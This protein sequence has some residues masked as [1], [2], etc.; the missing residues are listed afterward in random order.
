MNLSAVAK[1]AQA[2]LVMVLLLC[3]ANCGGG[4]TVTTGS[5]G[6]TATLLFLSKAADAFGV[7]VFSVAVLK[8]NG[9][10]IS[11][12]VGSDAAWSPDGKSIAF[13]TGDPSVSF[14]EQIFVMGADGSGLT[15]VTHEST[16][17]GP[18]G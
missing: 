10:S 1:V 3:L 18:A 12:H 16:G 7:R 13:D 8:D 9:A 11:L 6:S 17:V 4:G 5:G 15:Q 14:V 2:L